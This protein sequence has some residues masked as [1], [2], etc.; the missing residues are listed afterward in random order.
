MKKLTLLFLAFGSLLSNLA[1]ADSI[2]AFVSKV[3]N[4]N[5]EIASQSLIL[6]ASEARSKGVSLKAPM[7]GVSQ[8]RT[9]EEGVAYA[10]EVQQEVPLSSRLSSDKT[11]R[12]N[13]FELQR[14]E[15]EFFSTEK[16]LQA[17]LAFVSYWKDHEKINYLTEVRDWLK[18][19]LSY[20]RS[21]VRSDASSNIYALEIESY[22]G[23]LENDLSSVKS[24][25]E[26][27]KSKLKELS[28]DENYEPGLP[29][30]D[31]P[32]N[33]PEASSSSRIS[34]ISLSKLKV[35]SSMLE[36]AK[37]SYLPNL[38]IRARKLDRPMM[39][40]ANQEIMLGIDLPFAFFWQPRAEKAE[41]VA[42]KMIAEANYRKAEVESEALK[43]SLMKRSDI[44][45]NQIK[46]LKDVSIPAAQKSL[47]YLKNIAPRDMSGLETHRR[48][49]QDYISLRTQLVEL[50]MAYEEIYSNW[51]LAFAK[52]Q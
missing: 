3:K 42:N 6:T 49:F 8:M 34:S 23:V 40:M 45:K 17:R 12:E 39:F 7:V 18:N 31:D 1:I 13:A 47:K 10:F 30:I 38:I 15:S 52:E 35:A 16:V 14:K 43:Q 24:D 32:K 36:V 21:V 33:L 4:S 46:T 28:F 50:R 5:L 29:V 26:A 44:L 48:I 11:S 27:E 22:L 2:D 37:T 41:A 51:S 19:H 25:L 9:L 20:A